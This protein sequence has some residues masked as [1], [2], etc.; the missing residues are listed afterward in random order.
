MMLLCNL[1]CDN[2]ERSL[3]TTSAVIIITIPLWR[4]SVVPMA[5]LI[6]MAAF[7]AFLDAAEAYG[8]PAAQPPRA[9]WK[10]RVL[11]APLCPLADEARMHAGIVAVVVVPSTSH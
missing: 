6:G 1:R 4:E 5:C 10:P 7:H 3:L 11:D 8:P 9:A 2:D